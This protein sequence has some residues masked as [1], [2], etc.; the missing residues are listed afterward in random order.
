MWIVDAHE[1]TSEADWPSAGGGPHTWKM[2]NYEFGTKLSGLASARFLGSLSGN[3]ALYGN[4]AAGQNLH[5]CR[6][7]RT[8]CPRLR[9]HSDDGGGTWYTLFKSLRGTSE[10][11]IGVSQ[12]DAH[13]WI[14]W[15]SAFV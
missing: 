15:P 8:E 11:P 10:N 14:V 3:V 9:V 1:P 7:H 5:A 12:I 6:A 4:L 2:E 13:G